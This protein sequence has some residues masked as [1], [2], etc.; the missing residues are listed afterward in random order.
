MLKPQEGELKK[1]LI[2]LHK[3]PNTVYSL[4]NGKESV[5]AYYDTDFESDNGLDES[6]EG[7]EEFHCIVFRKVNDGTLFEVN[8]H[9][10]PEKVMC[11][12]VT[13]IGK[14]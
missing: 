11:K 14:E 9:N 10:L 12:G 1:L 2:Y 5:L 7:Y 8:Y 13:V 6:D 4:V 3:S